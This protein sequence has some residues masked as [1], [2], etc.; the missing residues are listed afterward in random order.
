MP[1]PGNALNITSPGLVVFD[2]TATF[3]ADTTT[4]YYTLV[5]A[6][7]NGISNI[8]PG[9]ANYVLT[10]NGASANPSYQA[11]PFTQLP[12]TDEA[13]SFSA[14][15]GNGYFITGTATA[16]LPSSPSQGN[17]IAFFVDTASILTI[18]AATGQLIRIGKAVSASAG[19]AKS[20]FQG[21][22]VTLVYRASDTQ[23]S[24]TSV[25]GT[26]TVT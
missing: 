11:I 18:Q 7:S 8:A 6:A 9:T 10:S 13:S 17:T 15:A 21:D 20:N 4:Q 1:T 14:V 3:T 22:T 12:W 23:W 5:G 2:G 19:T 16:T 24:S 26:F 25:V